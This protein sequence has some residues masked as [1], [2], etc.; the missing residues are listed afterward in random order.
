MLSSRSEVKIMSVQRTTL[1]LTRKELSRLLNVNDYI[2]GIGYAF[3]QHG[4]GKS[5]GTSMV[6]GETPSDLE[7]HIKAG[8]IV[9]KGKPYYAL[10]ANGSSFKNR[11]L[12]GLPNILGVIILYDG[13]SGFPLAVMESTELTRQRTAA[14][15]AVVLKL[16]APANASKLLLCG[17]GVQGRMHMKYL[18]E[19]LPIGE[20]F[21][22]DFQPDVGQMFA[23][24]MEEEYRIPVSAVPNLSF[25]ACQ[26]QVIVTC[27]PSRKPYLKAEYISPGTTIA[28]VGSDSP[29][30]QELDSHLLKGNKVIVDIL[31]Q[32]ASVGELH[33]ALLAGLMTEEDIYAEIG[34]VITGQKRGRETSD[35]IIIYD[36]TGTAIQDTAAAILVYEKATKMNIGLHIDLFD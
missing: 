8:G 16:L 35:E 3:H 29:A 14:G 20:I 22:Y 6:H 26:C 25:E 2:E 12:R 11:E 28:A 5:F 1:I 4:E 36:A 15:T 10:K 27:T 9:W 19:V 7:F 31:S 13:E 21:V 23:R 32:C 17:C 33:H 30:K 34:E 24:E 18:T